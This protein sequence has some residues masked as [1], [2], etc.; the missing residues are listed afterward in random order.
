[1]GRTRAMPARKV[2]PMRRQI[3]EEAILEPLPEEKPPAAPPPGV[4]SL[5]AGGA[6]GFKG[7]VGGL[8][9]GGNAP[10]GMA[11]P[12]PGPAGGRRGG[13]SGFTGTTPVPYNA[14]GPEVPAVVKILD[15][16]IF[17]EMLTAFSLGVVTFTFVLLLNKILRLVELIVNKGVPVSV[18]LQLFLYL[19]PYSLVVT[20]PMATLLAC[21]A[22]Y[23][24]M[25]A[26]NEIT[27]LKVTGL[28]LYRLIVPA[29]VFGMAAYAVTTYLTV[30]LLPFSNRALKGLVYQITRLQA[31]VGIQEGVFNSDFPGLTIYVHKLDDGNGILQGV[32]I[33][34]RRDAHDQRVVVAGEGRLFSDPER[35]R[36]LLRLQ[37]GSRHSAPR[38]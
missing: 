21:L 22:S 13:E 27:V 16:Y 38:A 3:R 19:L 25:A 2:S 14:P 24:R 4:L 30:S 10:G 11:P 9:R 36:I 7:F 15:R 34:D 26:D 23:G 5:I 32:F 6:P 18:L 31:T 37:D 35:Y 8:R 12:G 1:M 33:V 28:S 29:L 20:I 17:R